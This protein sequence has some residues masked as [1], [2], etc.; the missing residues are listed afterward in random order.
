MMKKYLPYANYLAAGAGVLAALLRQWT[1]VAGTD[2]KGLY[3]AA[4]P[5][6]IGYLVVMTLAIAAFF[7]LTRHCKDGSDWKRD[8][9]TGP[10]PILGQLAAACGIAIYS[11][12]LLQSHR[13]GMICGILG[14]CATGALLVLSWQRF[15]QKPPFA[16]AYLIPCLFFALQLFLLGKTH[17]N[18]TQLLRILPQ[19]LAFALS[20]LASYELTGFG[21]GIGNRS[22]SL[23]WSL[24]A[25]S[26]CFAAVPGG[27]LFFLG[28][29]LWHLLSHCS[30]TEP[31]EEE[32]Q[33]ATA[34]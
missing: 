19:V 29:G 11:L 33:E 32:P 22:R 12:P 31:A 20:A 13:I 30:L 9:P 3:P 4:H 6:Q 26:L 16:P 28:L 21:L 17:G 25:A 34:A 23:L 24:C 5:G 8:F 1:L 2:A 10:L 18:E 15:Q 7:L 14:F 27:N